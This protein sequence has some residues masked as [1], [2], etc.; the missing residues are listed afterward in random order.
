MMRTSAAIVAV[1]FLV[2]AMLGWMAPG[3][4]PP[5]IV[6]AE[7]GDFARVQD[8]ID[9]AEDGAVIVIRAGTYRENLAVARPVT[10]LAEDGVVLEPADGDQPA[11]TVEGTQAVAIHGLTIRRAAVG[12]QISVDSCTVSGCSISATKIGIE[13]VAF[14]GD[15]VSIVD[16]VLRSDGYGVGVQVTGSGVT[17]LARCRLHGFGTGILLGGA[18]TAVVQGCS[19]EG[20]YEAVVVS[21]STSALLVGNVLMGNHAS[22]IRLEPAPGALRVGPLCLIGNVIQ[23]NDGWGLTLCGLDGSAADT[24][25]GRVTGSGNRVTGNGRGRLCPGDLRLPDGFLTD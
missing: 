21:S 2:V 11:V 9:V 6:S 16:T 12:C 20:C 4:A 25:F 10:L 8:A 14:D 15:I 23:D 1:G 18:G 7:G 5:Q 17:L 22:A 13:I 24:S 19:A 3:A